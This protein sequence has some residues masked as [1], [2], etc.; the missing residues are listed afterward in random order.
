MLIMMRIQNYPVVF[1]HSCASPFEEDETLLYPQY[2]INLGSI[3][4][5]MQLEVRG[6]NS[7]IFGYYKYPSQ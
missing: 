2:Y 6:H 1:S 3:L 7:T 5:Y 4:Y